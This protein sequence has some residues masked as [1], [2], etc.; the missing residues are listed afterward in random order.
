ML[1][2]FHVSPPKMEKVPEIRVKKPAMETNCCLTSNSSASTIKDEVVMNN[3]NLIPPKQLKRTIS[4][5]KKATINL[6]FSDVKYTV[7]EWSLKKG[8]GE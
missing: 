5:A 2:T 4:F 7:S 1:K 6:Q 3:N 8:R